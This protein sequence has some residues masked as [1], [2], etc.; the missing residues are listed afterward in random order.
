M[1]ELNLAENICYIWLFF[2]TNF[3]QPYGDL[4][5]KLLNIRPLHDRNYGQN[6]LRRSLD[7]MIFLILC[8]LNIMKPNQTENYGNLWKRYAG[9]HKVGKLRARC[10]AGGRGPSMDA[11]SFANSAFVYLAPN[12]VISNGVLSSY[13]AAFLWS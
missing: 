6:C 10:I 7:N 9:A 11:S 2:R 5:H 1:L 12:G 13:A 3:D 4:W 8:L